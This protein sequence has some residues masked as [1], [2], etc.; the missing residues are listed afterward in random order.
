MR[1]SDVD[2]DEHPLQTTALGLEDD[3]EIL[4]NDRSRP[5]VVDGRHKRQQQTLAWRRRNESKYHTVIELVGNGTKYHLLC[6]GDS[7]IRPILYKESDWDDHETNKIGERPRYSRAG[8]RVT[9]IDVVTE[10]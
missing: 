7:D 9:S 6:T 8:E 4:I 2:P 5:L 1:D 10:D 3:D